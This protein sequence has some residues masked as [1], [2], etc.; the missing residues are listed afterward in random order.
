MQIANT[1]RLQ[2]SLMTLDDSA[3]LFE[4]DQDERVMHFLNGGIKSTQHQIDT[5]MIPRLAQYLNPKKVGVYG[6]SKR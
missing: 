3:L 4:L 2:L 6:K 5:V 1:A